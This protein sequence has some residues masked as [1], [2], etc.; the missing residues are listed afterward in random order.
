MIERYCPGGSWNGAPG[1]IKELYNRPD[2]RDTMQ[3]MADW[4]TPVDL[5]RSREY[6]SQIVNSIV[7]GEKEIIY[8][9][10]RND[11]LIGNLPNESC[12]EVPCL[13]DGNGIS[14]IHVGELPEHLAAIN[15]N[16]INVQ[17]LA[18][19]ASLESDP[20]IL[21]QAMCLDPLTA[22]ILT[23]D[24]IREMTRELLAAHSDYLPEEFR[25]K[26]LAARPLMYQ[27]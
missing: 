19:M 5:E 7:S 25:G 24:E 9:N 12:V 1:F 26:T 18:V 13:V 15:R 14:P 22:S 21:F 3:K 27:Q 16:Q 10:V 11:N 4:E 2:W 6:G 23:L 8:G 20:E 17:K